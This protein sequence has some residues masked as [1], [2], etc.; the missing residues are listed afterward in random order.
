MV[1]FERIYSLARNT[2]RESLRS[3]V[4]YSLFFFAALLTAVSAFFGSVTIGDQV[5]VI[6]DF[7]LFAIS[8]FAVAYTVISG[9]SLLYKELA[10]KTIF[11]ILSKPVR[12]LEFLVGKF[13]GMYATVSLMTLLMGA[14]FSLFVFL[15]EQKV[16]PNLV[17]AYVHILFELMIVCAAAILFSSIVV[18]PMLIGLFT[19]GLFLAGRSIEILLYF[20]NEGLVSGFGASV[21]QIVYWC[22]PQLEAISVANQ[23]VYG[24]TIPFQW[25]LMAGVYAVC[26]SAVLLVL[27]QILFSRREFN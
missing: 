12:R 1:M 8:L 14:G 20:V 7:G 10:R 21:V 5:K 11:T 3:K 15:F 24:D 26:Y 17:T 27:A 25:T 6:K 18:T 23:V 22:L 4:L 19:F 13:L 9:S 16:S 2:F